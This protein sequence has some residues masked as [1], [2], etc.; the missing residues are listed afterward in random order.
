MRS[1][2]TSIVATCY[3][4]ALAADA[5]S[6][7]HISAWRPFSSKKFR[8]VD[9]VEGQKILPSHALKRRS[10]RWRLIAKGISETAIGPLHFTFAKLLHL[11]DGFSKVH[12]AWR[13]WATRIEIRENECVQRSIGRPHSVV[14][15]LSTN[16]A[17]VHILHFLTFSI[18][19]C[20]SIALR[21]D[22]PNRPLLVWRPVKPVT[23]S[24]CISYCA[25]IPPVYCQDVTVGSAGTCRPYNIIH[26]VLSQNAP[27]R[28]ERSQFS[29][30]SSDRKFSAG[31]YLYTVFSLALLSCP[32]RQLRTC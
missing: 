8:L 5:S 19:Q 4:L 18:H 10:R 28:L 23:R 24:R 20:E 17:T 27:R 30:V 14:S 16:T 25:A 26:T 3:L 21:F 7:R 2:A 31:C 22:Q 15:R 6:K 1:M 29:N 13:W 9:F 11:R 32:G 12:S